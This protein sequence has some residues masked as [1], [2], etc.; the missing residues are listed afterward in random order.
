MRAVRQTRFGAQDGNCFETC[1]A[2]VLELD[3][4]AQ[5]P[6]FTES[7]RDMRPYVARGILKLEPTRENNP[8][9]LARLRDE[10]VCF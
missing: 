5:V 2:G 4:I 7:N 9:L 8:Q 1:I 3:D 10:T 6:R